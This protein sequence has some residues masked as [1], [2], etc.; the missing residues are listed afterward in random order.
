MKKPSL[1]GK[2]KY[3]SSS[4]Y[5]RAV[6]VFFLMDKGGYKVTMDVDSA[7]YI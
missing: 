4:C 1:R 7:G 3:K 2:K 5:R 6:H